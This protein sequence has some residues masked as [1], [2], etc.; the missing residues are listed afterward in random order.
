MEEIKVRKEVTIRIHGSAEYSSEELTD[1]TDFD[2]LVN[3]YFKGNKNRLKEI[4]DSIGD[5]KVNSV[6][7]NFEFNSVTK[8]VQA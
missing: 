7:R 2:Q 8:D 4:F 3:I 6:L 1:V 5:V